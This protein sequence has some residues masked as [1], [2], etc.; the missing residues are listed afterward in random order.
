MDE[1]WSFYKN[2][3]NQEWLAFVFGTR[4]HSCLDRLLNLLKPFGIK[5]FFTD[6]NFA[7][8]SKIASDSLEIGKRNTQKIERQHL[9]LRTRIKRLARKTVC[10]SKSKIIHESVIGAFINIFYFKNQLMDMIF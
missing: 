10:F 3:K 9:T 1:M 6:N 5:K 2:K 8:G 4:E 7:Y